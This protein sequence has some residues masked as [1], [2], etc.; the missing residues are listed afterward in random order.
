MLHGSVVIGCKTRGLVLIDSVDVDVLLVLLTSVCNKMMILYECTTSFANI[1]VPDLIFCQTY[2]T[3]FM[4]ASCTAYIYGKTPM[5]V[6]CVLLCSL[7]PKDSNQWPVSM[8]ISD[9]DIQ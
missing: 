2:V 1:R 3:F 5:H 8:G 4:S 6:S 7:V 9:A